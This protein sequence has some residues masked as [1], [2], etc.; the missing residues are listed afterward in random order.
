METNIYGLRASQA[1][2]NP[3]D[4]KNIAQSKS[5]LAA[6][7]LAKLKIDEQ[8]VKDAGTRFIEAAAHAPQAWDAAQAFL[9]Y[10]SY[11]NVDI[12]PKLTPATGKSKYQPSVTSI[13]NPEYP[14]TQ[15][16]Y[17]ISFAG[18]YATPDKSARLETL[19][20]PQ[21]EGS[22]FAFF[23]IEGGMDTIVLDGE[24]MKHVIVQNAD[25]QYDGGPIRLED[26]YFVNCTFHSKFKLTPTT[27][28]LGREIL[29][30]AAVTFGSGTQPASGL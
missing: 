23:K 18:G 20:N 12:V 30:A 28:R 25:V 16:A 26:V 27:I 19:T 13:P 29:T 24:Y 4:P 15:R 11:L 5:V 6:A 10:R 3:T 9:D 2:Q 22:E 1:S 17:S 7:R 14:G 21:S 8:V